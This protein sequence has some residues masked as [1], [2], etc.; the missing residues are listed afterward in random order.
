MD[1]VVFFQELEGVEQLDGEAS[2]QTERQ[3][4]KVVQFEEFVQVDTHQF[5]GDAQV[6]PEDHIVFHMNDVHGVIRVVLF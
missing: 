4:F 3:S 2:H 1:H 5:K 6:L